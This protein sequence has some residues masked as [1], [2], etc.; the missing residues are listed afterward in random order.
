MKKNHSSNFKKWI[1]CSALILPL[2]LMIQTANMQTAAAVKD[3]K[4]HKAS[5]TSIEKVQA[6]QKLD[7]K[8]SE[9]NGTNEV[10]KKKIS[11]DTIVSLTDRF[12]D[13]LVQEL[14]KHNKVVHYD[15]KE[16]LLDEF[17]NIATRKT[18]SKYVDFYFKEKADGLY[19]IP[20]ETPAWFQKNRNYD[21]IRKDENVVQ[22]VQQN[23]SELY[24]AYTVV[25][26]FTYKDKWMITNILHK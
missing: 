21:M 4:S 25:F 3:G 24:G 18:A 20:T 6:F 13:I 26:E 16:T 12:R 7:E 5:I 22:V 10:G 8:V 1:F 23:K 14:D 17:E 15:S 19:V 9:K 2:L 11:R